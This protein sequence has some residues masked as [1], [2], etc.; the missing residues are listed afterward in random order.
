MI[1]ITKSRNHSHFWIHG[2][3]LYESYKTIRGQ[4]FREIIEVLWPD[5]QILSD[6]DMITITKIVN[7]E[8]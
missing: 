8:A 3:K 2:C 5:S 6:D 7:G 1:T 4:R